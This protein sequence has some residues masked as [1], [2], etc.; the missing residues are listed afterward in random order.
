M[1][2]STSFAH[3]IDGSQEGIEH[4]VAV[5]GLLALKLV[6]ITPSLRPNTLESLRFSL[7]YNDKLEL[8]AN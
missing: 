8:E 3:F 2:L 7:K 4:V 1:S 5:F 6:L